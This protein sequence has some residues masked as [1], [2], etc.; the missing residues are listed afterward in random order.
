LEPPGNEPG[1]PEPPEGAEPDGTEPEGND[2]VGAPLPPN[3]PAP[4][5]G[6]VTPFFFKQAVYALCDA[7]VDFEEEEAQD[8]VVLLVL[9][10]EGD[11]ELLPH[12]ATPSARE[13]KTSPRTSVFDRFDLSRIRAVLDNRRKFVVL[14]SDLGDLEDRKGQTWE[15]WSFQ[16]CPSRESASPVEHS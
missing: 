5:D 3:P 13:T 16:P 6:I 1:V 4:P 2:P 10:D 9:V 14:Y 11:P 15:P 7:F 12:A 8:F